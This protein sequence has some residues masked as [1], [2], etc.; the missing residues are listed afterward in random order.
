MADKQIDPTDADRQSYRLR[1]RTIATGNA[2]PPSHAEITTGEQEEHPVERWDLEV[3]ETSPEVDT[4]PR[5]MP[6][7]SPVLVMEGQNLDTSSTII[8]TPPL[9][10][11]PFSPHTQV[12][13]DTQKYHDRQH[14]PSPTHE[15]SEITT[16]QS[17]HTQ[18][19]SHSIMACLLYTS[20]SPRD[21]LLSR[22]PS[23]A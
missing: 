11:G 10:Q 12:M 19:K 23:S 17:D 18:L 14:Y 22:M 2:P 13:T 15:Q 7:L 4:S 16:A 21:G 20:P 9:L 8:H 3:A 1:S 5:E 6:Q